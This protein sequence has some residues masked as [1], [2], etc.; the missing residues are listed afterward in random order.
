MHSDINNN[1]AEINCQLLRTS[2]VLSTSRWFLTGQFADRES[3][4]V[5]EINCSPFRIGRQQEMSLTLP[6]SFISSLHAEISIEHDT[7]IVRDLNSTNGTFKNGERVTQPTPVCDGDC[8]TFADLPFVVNHVPA[9]APVESARETNFS[10]AA[11]DFDRFLKTSEIVPHFQSIVSLENRMIVGCEVLARSRIEGLQTPDEMFKTASRLN[12]QAELSRK[13]RMVGFQK[14]NMLWQAPHLFINTHA[15]EL[16]TIGLLDSLRRI[17]ELNATLPITLEI[18]EPKN[19][20]TELIQRFREKL[21]T[22]Q[23]TLAYDHFGLGHTGRAELAVVR[24]DYVKFDMNLIREIHLA[25]SAQQ[26]LL[27]K[28]VHM[29]RDLGIVPVAMGIESDS[30]HMVCRKFGFELGQGFLYGKPADSV[31]LT[32]NLCPETNSSMGTLVTA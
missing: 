9:S 28:M 16:S 22:L 24:P 1:L 26:T 27:A 18:R 3:V 6:R 4:P 7:L 21:H 30:E 14:G 2:P 8:L 5:V 32:T 11:L 29:V 12:V 15:E 17:R 13:L 19:H 20:E 23:M 31:T 10:D 25:P